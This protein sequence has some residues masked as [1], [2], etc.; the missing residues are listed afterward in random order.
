MNKPNRFETHALLVPAA[1][2]LAA[3]LLAWLLAG[4]GGGEDL[5]SLHVPAAPPAAATASPLPAVRQ[6]LRLEGC[7][8]DEYFIPRGDAPV[9][10]LGPDGRLLA[11]A[12]SNA[13]G[14]FKLQVPAGQTISLA[15]DRPGG[16]VLK[17][18]TGQHSR[19]L[20][21]CLLDPSA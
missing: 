1:A 4:C 15:I 8:V 16:D 17:V 6:T 2:V 18:A 7:V 21:T 3:L 19:A 20:T 11:N 9:R 10:A 12:Q 14:E 5:L 13:H